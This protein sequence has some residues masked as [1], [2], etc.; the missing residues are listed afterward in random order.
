MLFPHNPEPNQ[1]P[2]N[3]MTEALIRTQR[4]MAALAHE[5]RN[6]LTA[7]LLSL[8]ELHPI[9]VSEPSA[10]Q[11]RQ[12]ARDS[13][14]HMATVIDDVLE[15]Y[16]ATGSRLPNGTERTELSRIVIGAVR[17]SHLQM[18]RKG[19]RLSVSLPSPDLMLL[20]HPSR[21]QQILTNLL[22]NAARY[23]E[24]G[25]EITLEVL[26]SAAALMISVRDNGVG[27]TPSFISQLFNRQRHQNPPH[28]KSGQGFGIGLALVQSLVELAGG[29]VTAHSDGP[30]KGSEFRVRLPNCVVQ[31]TE[32]VGSPNQTAALMAK[33][34]V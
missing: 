27:M 22:S 20:T 34:S 13:A 11:T 7:I 15:L 32:T 31:E 12:L 25:G 24:P 9:C 33:R 4:C 5:L 30:G 10:C 29:T 28:R 16:R 2:D 18:A 17:S 1:A 19:H 3:A 21:L 14:L 6:P 26:H 8:D 23:T